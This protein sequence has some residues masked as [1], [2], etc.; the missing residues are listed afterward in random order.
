MLTNYL[1]AR[2]GREKFI[3]GMAITLPALFMFYEGTN[4]ITGSWVY[5]VSWHWIVLGWMPL[6]LTFVGCHRRRSVVAKVAK[7]EYE[8]RN[9]NTRYALRGLRVMLIIIMFPLMLASLVRLL[10]EITKLREA[11]IS[12]RTY[13]KELLLMS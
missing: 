6:V 2:L 13:A 11:N 9:I 10:A 4:L 3:R 1:W 5:T 8:A 7:A 12:V